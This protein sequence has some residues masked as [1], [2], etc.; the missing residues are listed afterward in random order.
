MRHQRRHSIRR[1]LDSRRHSRK[2]NKPAATTTRTELQQ[3][4]VHSQETRRDRTKSQQYRGLD[5]RSIGQKRHQRRNSIRRNLDS[6]RHSRKQNRPAAATRIES[7]QNTVHS[8]KHV[9]IEPSPSSTVDATTG[10]SAGNDAEK[11]NMYQTQK[12]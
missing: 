2:Q 6:R 10:A 11:Q 7:Q 12:G 5:H 3:N 9:E 4:T 1:Y 8:K